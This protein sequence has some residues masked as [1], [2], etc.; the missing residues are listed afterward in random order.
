MLQ[1]NWQTLIDK[2]SAQSDWVGI[3]EY[4]EITDMITAR[5]GKPEPTN[6]DV[7]HGVMVEV[8]KEGQFAYCGTVDLTDS[9]VST[10]FQRALY[11]AESCSKHKI[12]PFDKS[13]RPAN[14]GSYKSAVQNSIDSLSFAEIQ[15]KMIT[16]TEQMKVGEEIIDRW[17]Y[18]RLIRT[19][20]HYTCSNGSEWTQ[21]FSIVSKDFGCTAQSGKEVQNR[22][23]GLNGLQTG[24]E[25]LDDTLLAENAVRV[26]KQAIEL[27][28][29]ADCPSGSRDLILAPDQLYLQVHESIGHPLEI[30][31]ILGD[32]RNY[33]GWSFI[34]PEDFGT[35]QYGSE[36]MNVTFDPTIE[37]EMA[38]YAFD[39]NGVKATREHIIKDGKLLR[40]LGGIESQTRSGLPG[41][42]CARSADW[43]RP[44]MDRMAN[45]NLEPGESSLD[46][47]IAAT[48]KG[49]FMES[50]RSWSIDDYR[51]KFQFG[52]EYGRIIKDG[53]L[54]EVVKNPN[55]RGVT[56]PFWN[57]LKMVGNEAT[58]EIYGSPY[59]GKGEPNQII[60]VGHTVP[61]CLFS[62]IE[63]FGGA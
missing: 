46:E 24:L 45:L 56:T 2:F 18:S 61:I 22:S 52:C 57:N 6:S 21:E 3:R 37:T 40:G 42:A 15:Q 63:V 49:I 55:Y 5:N 33:A 7:S 31:R 38:S 48:E 14:S 1:A 60:R 19:A 11:L 4:R 16:V 13:I 51:N 53:E 27:L 20:I 47:M 29:A 41:V 54:K 58:R 26:G 39:D 34:S 10:A 12:L 8:L 30:D 23:F 32:E 59:C 9:G 28:S 44:P 36:L 17:A 62:D 50:N 43:S 35:L 25:D